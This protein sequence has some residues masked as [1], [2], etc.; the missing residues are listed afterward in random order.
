LSTRFTKSK[1]DGVSIPTGYEGNNI[2]DD[3]IVPSC[4]IEDVDRAL[5]NLF[6]DELPLIYQQKNETKRIPIIFATGERFAVL[7]RKRPLRDNQGALILPLISIMRT[8]IEQDIGRGVGPGQGAPITIKKKLGKE[9]PSYQALVN[10][11]GLQNQDNVAADTHL[12]GKGSTRTIDLN[13]KPTGAKAGTV[14]SRTGP[15]GPN[16]AARVGELLDPDIGN[17]IYEIITMPPVKYFT[18]TYDIT[19]WTQYTVQMNDM[20]TAMMSAYQ[21]NHQRTF[22][23]E[24]E[25]GYWFVAYVANSLSPGN[26]FD[27]FTDEERI[28]RYN[29]T[30]EVP[31]YVVLPDFPGAQT[32]LR[33]FVSAPRISF[34][35]METHAQVN[36]ISKGGL[37][38][39]YPDSYILQNLSDQDSLIPSDAIGSSAVA[40]TI[41]AAGGS[42]PGAAEATADDRSIQDRRGGTAAVRR[43]VSADV[44]GYTGRSNQ[45][46]TKYIVVQTDPFTGEK[47]ER[48]MTIKSRVSRKG[49]TV[50]RGGLIDD[51]ESIR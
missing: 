36:A 45:V 14:A 22:R 15:V 39:G 51:L 13:R 3:L 50:L 29:F 2:P 7:R 4:T 30:V 23:L 17:N 6:N 40:N 35:V 44:G 49:E 37:P 12:T 42:A 19:F 46:G 33:K 48:V 25:K 11:L 26:N 47:I 41:T 20:I 31:G 18:A 24:T 34:D 10:K 28:V 5:F 1:S 16:S 32:G 38:S 27:S 43:P 9:D 8:G 21:N